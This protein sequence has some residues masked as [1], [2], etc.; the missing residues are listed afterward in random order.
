MLERQTSIVSCHMSNFRKDQCLVI[1]RPHQKAQ[2]QFCRKTTSTCLKFQAQL[3]P[4]IRC[5]LL[6]F[7]KN[8][9]VENLKSISNPAGN[10]NIWHTIVE[11]FNVCCKHVGYNKKATYFWQWTEAQSDFS[12]SPAVIHSGLWY[13]HASRLINNSR[14]VEELLILRAP[15]GAIVTTQD[16]FDAQLS[17]NTFYGQA[18]MNCSTAASDC[19]RH[20]SVLFCLW[21]AQSEVGHVLQVQPQHIASSVLSY[22]S[23]AV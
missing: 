6:I 2:K 21:V 7:H 9:S 18:N 13:W 15:H 1:V 11:M 14:A 12:P 16:A 22:S 10:I 5:I 8:L 23:S 3:M 20:L 4:L 17:F 19:L